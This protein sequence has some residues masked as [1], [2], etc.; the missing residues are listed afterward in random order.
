MDTPVLIQLRKFVTYVHSHTH[1]THMRAH[2]HH[3]YMHMH[4][5]HHIISC[6]ILFPWIH[7]FVKMTVG[8]GINHK[9]T[10]YTKYAKFT[11]L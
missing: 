1:H 11:E 5:Y 9:H 7:K 4:A 3:M 10:K 2:T 6:R 8:C